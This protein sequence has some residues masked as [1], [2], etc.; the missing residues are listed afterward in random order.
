MFLMSYRILTD[1]VEFVVK[2]WSRKV[3]LQKDWRHEVGVY[4]P[5]PSDSHKTLQKIPFD[6]E[7]FKSANRSF[8]TFHL[9]YFSRLWKFCRFYK[10]VCNCK[11]CHFTSRRRAERWAAGPL[12]PK[13]FSQTFRYNF[14]M[15]T[16]SPMNLFVF[17][18]LLID[19]YPSCDW[20]QLL[21]TY[22]R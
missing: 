2:F 5:P 14:L 7:E 22:K 4:F 9:H 8:L 11:S 18:T 1:L 15:K 20:Y 12:A 10:T 6:Y 21:T 3:W 13:H 19:L 16:A 17:V